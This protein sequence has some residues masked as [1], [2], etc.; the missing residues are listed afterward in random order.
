[1]FQDCLL[2]IFFQ[3]LDSNQWVV[4]DLGQ[5]LLVCGVVTQG[6]GKS[7]A[8]NAHVSTRMRSTFCAAMYFEYVLIFCCN[9]VQR[10]LPRISQAADMRLID[11]AHLQTT[12]LDFIS[13]SPS[14]K[15]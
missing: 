2:M 15:F 9:G 10:V 12:L 13:G 4:V 11:D 7:K 5:T 3:V 14:I 1:M 6:R 8:L